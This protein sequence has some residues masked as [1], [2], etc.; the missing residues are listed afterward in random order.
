[1]IK[2]KKYWLINTDTYANTAE[3]IFKDK[4]KFKKLNDDPTLTNLITVQN[5]LKTK[6]GE[7]KT[8]NMRPK[9]ACT[10]CEHDLSKTHK[11]FIIIPPFQPITDT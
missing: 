8:E 3:G 7:I 11:Y 9:F 4:N 6:R 2:V 5:Y 1:M 10:G